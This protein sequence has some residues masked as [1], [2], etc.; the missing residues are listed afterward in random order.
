MLA[1]NAGRDAAG[2]TK[3]PVLHPLAKRED[4]KNLSVRGVSRGD[5]VSGKRNKSHSDG[6]MVVKDLAG[7]LRRKTTARH[8]TG[9][10]TCVGSVIML[11]LLQYL[12]YMARRR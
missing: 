1:V 8:H 7:K 2:V 6:A 10:I 12:P 4:T 11:K 3:F 5:H 9:E